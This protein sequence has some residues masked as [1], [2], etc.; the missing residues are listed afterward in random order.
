M[1]QYVKFLR[2]T[3]T[4]YKNLE[5]KDSDT[6]Y[7]IYEE[8]E[9]TGVLYLGSK[10]IAGSEAGTDT[11]TSSFLS[12]LKDVLISEGLNDSSFLVY[13][14]EA[15]AWVNKSLDDLLF[16]G[17]TTES[18]GIAGLVPAPEKDQTNLF[19][20]SDGTWSAPT[21]DHT[22][23]TLENKD[24]SL[25]NDLISAVQNNFT[26][27]SG[28]IIIIKDLIVN[29]KWQYT[30][31]VYDNEAWHAMDGN[32]DAENVYFSEDLITTT[33]IGNIELTDG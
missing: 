31:Y 20:K 24:K 23:L 4:A 29:D 14:E 21:I 1:A 2:G 22:I 17:A 10:L 3:P 33:A 19:L 28:D 27:V 5:T 11:N 18:G 13:D 6:L 7:F 9:S 8:D 26:P 16:V 25:H 30:A 32:Y 15:V 12:D